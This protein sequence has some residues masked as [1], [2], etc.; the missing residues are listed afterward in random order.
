M[1]FDQLRGKLDK[2]KFTRRPRYT[3]VLH[4]V[5]DKF[6]L[7]LNTYVVVDSIHKLSSSNP[8]YPYCRMSKEDL[9]EFLKLG[10]A[11]VY[12]SLQEAEKLNLIVRSDEGVRATEKWINAVEIYSIKKSA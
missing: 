12:R 2:Q 11:T 9:A 5:R 6:D 3:V 7:S 10:R 4:Q 8:N 1:S